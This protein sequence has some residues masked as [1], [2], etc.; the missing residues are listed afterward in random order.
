MNGEPHI[1]HVTATTRGAGHTRERKNETLEPTITSRGTAPTA[2][3]G[4]VGPWAPKC[5]VKGIVP[6]L[7]LPRI[8]PPWSRDIWQAPRPVA[9][10]PLSRGVFVTVCASRL[11]TGWVQQ[12]LLRLRS[13][14]L[15][16]L[17]G[18]YVCPRGS[19]AP[20]VRPNHSVPFVLP[21]NVVHL[22]ALVLHT[23][24]LGEAP[25]ARLFGPLAA[26]RGFPVV[27]KHIYV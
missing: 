3:S 10:C 21:A 1:S 6:E 11:G 14:R 8:S 22:V 17:G 13:L 16:D 24:N 18:V 4:L 9:S 5:S 26:G 25:L 7:L 12:S 15:V 19:H 20:R 2:V 23:Y 27:V